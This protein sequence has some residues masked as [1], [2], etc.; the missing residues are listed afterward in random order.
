MPLVIEFTITPQICLLYLMAQCSK[1]AITGHA[2]NGITDHSFCC[3][4]QCRV[5][6]W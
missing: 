1:V 2:V 3:H 5:F 4:E 6:S